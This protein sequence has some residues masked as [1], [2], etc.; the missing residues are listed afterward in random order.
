MIHLQ[1]TIAALKEC[2][3]ILS[4]VKVFLN[5]SRLFLFVLF[6]FVLHAAVY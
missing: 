2:M 6:G 1:T 4:D 3:H 5:F